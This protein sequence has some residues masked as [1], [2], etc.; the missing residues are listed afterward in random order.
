MM[1]SH[2]I[3]WYSV[4]EAMEHMERRGEFGIG[5]YLFASALNGLQQVSA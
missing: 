5:L 2:H 1:Q 4:V 3:N